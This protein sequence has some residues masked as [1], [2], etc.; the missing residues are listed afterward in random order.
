MTCQVLGGII[1]SFQRRCCYY[2]R[3]DEAVT[4]ELINEILKDIGLESIHDD[5]NRK[6]E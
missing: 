1:S 2:E 5:E 6:E 4:R 3:G